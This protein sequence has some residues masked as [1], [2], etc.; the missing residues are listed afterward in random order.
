MTMLTNVKI[1]TEIN[2]PP[3]KKRGFF[4]PLFKSRRYLTRMK[5]YDY[6][7][8]MRSLQLLMNKHNNCSPPMSYN[9]HMFK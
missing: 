8:V 5:S 3:G 1:D 2:I 9:L 7:I 4:H 6:L